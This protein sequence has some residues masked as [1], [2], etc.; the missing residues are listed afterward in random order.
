MYIFFRQARI[1]DASINNVFHSE[2]SY[3]TKYKY[4]TFFGRRSLGVIR[5]YLTCRLILQYAIMIYLHFSFAFPR[6]SSTKLKNTVSS[7]YPKSPHT[8]GYS[9]KLQ[10]IV[11]CFIFFAEVGL[12]PTLTHEMSFVF[13]KKGHITFAISLSLSRFTPQ[14]TV[15]KYSKE[16][17][18]FHP[19]SLPL[20]GNIATFH[21]FTT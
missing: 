17:H 14:A 8:Q 1:P 19:D 5:S 20:T 11:I 18:I 3:N 2:S 21:P 15:I 6:R 13:I 4:Q 16:L 9:Y 7:F 12:A 10:Q